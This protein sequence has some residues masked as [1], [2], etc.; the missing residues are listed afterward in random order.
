PSC[1]C[2]RIIRGPVDRLS[3]RLWDGVAL[4]ALLSASSCQ[5]DRGETCNC[6]AMT[7]ILVVV[8]ASRT[9]DVVSVTASGAACEGA[10]HPEGTG[11][12]QISIRGAGSCHVVVSFRTGLPFSDDVDVKPCSSGACCTACGPYPDHV[13][14]VPSSDGG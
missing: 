11:D 9:A 12:Y 7:G 10:T 5:A 14:M 4:V 2:E 13:V 8:P 6:P 1:R 3:A